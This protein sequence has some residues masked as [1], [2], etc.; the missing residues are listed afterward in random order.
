MLS[1]T[2]LITVGSSLAV[3]QSVTTVIPEPAGTSLSPEPIP[4]SGD[5]DG[6]GF[7]YDRDSQ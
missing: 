1:A 5:F 3:A 2:L 7:L 4:I 6:E